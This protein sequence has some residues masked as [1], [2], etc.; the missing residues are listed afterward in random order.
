L[1]PQPPPPRWKRTANIVAAC[2]LVLASLLGAI[3]LQ[4]FFAPLPAGVSV[5]DAPDLDED[6]RRATH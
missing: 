3:L 2:A 1:T 6:A 4:W 5:T